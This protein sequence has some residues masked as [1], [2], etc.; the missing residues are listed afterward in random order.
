MY[1]FTQACQEIYF[2]PLHKLSR[3]VAMQKGTP[4]TSLSITYRENGFR[5]LIKEN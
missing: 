5:E 2:A 3:H 1:P 4:K